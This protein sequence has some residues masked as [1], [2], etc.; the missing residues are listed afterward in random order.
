MKVPTTHNVQANVAKEALGYRWPLSPQGTHLNSH[1]HQPMDIEP[2]TLDP[3]GVQS[4]KRRQFDPCGVTFRHNLCP[5][6]CAHGYSNWS[7][8]GT[9]RRRSGR[10]RC[11]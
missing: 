2:E 4:P 10:T 9:E 8:A 6:A 7:P 5:W 3:A 1:G 11:H